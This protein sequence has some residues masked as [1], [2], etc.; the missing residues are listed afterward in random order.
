[1]H[2]RHL[3]YTK[4]SLETNTSTASILRG[5]RLSDTIVHV[6]SIKRLLYYIDQT[7]LL[8]F[9]TVQLYLPQALYHV[10]TGHNSELFVVWPIAMQSICNV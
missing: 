1:M 7:F 6:Q 10:D 2:Y 3:Y 8:H 4:N 9:G 5:R